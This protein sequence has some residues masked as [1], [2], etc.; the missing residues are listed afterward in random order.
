MGGS[1]LLDSAGNHLWSER[2]DRLETDVF[3]VQTEI[4]QQL[5]NQLAG[6][7]GLVQRAERDAA[8]RKRPEK[9]SAYELYLLSLS[10]IGP[11]IR[12]CPSLSPADRARPTRS[13]LPAS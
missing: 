3:A 5:S 13:G 7:A 1:K 12:P 6:G 8:R 2:W 4:A 11:S 10:P 9:L